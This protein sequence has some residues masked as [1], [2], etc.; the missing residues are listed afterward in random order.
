MP[1]HDIRHPPTGRFA[2][3][4]QKALSDSADGAEAA[5]I[6]AT[7]DPTTIGALPGNLH[8]HH[9]RSVGFPTEHTIHSPRDKRA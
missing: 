7:P 9:S 1:R 5:M 3:A 6:P 4:E 8:P 2:P